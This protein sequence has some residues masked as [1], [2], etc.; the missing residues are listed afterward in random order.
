M[1][2]P[3][4]GCRFPQFPLINPGTF[5]PSILPS[6]HPKSNLLL[7]SSYFCCL[8]HIERW[9][10]SIRFIHPIHLK[11]SLCINV[12]L[13][14]LC[15][16]TMVIMVNHGKSWWIPMHPSIHPSPRRAAERHPHGFPR[17]GRQGVA[18]GRRLPPRGFLCHRLR[19]RRQ[20]GL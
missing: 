20:G 11:S 19:D 2:I 12:S 1:I 16:L 3:G 6:I 10:H 13:W 15:W 17:G 14:S 18:E 8:N 7:V 5:H 9:N 4:F